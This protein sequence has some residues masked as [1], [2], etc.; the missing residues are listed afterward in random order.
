MPT[1]MH[2]TVSVKAKLAAFRK[3]Y[4][5]T[6]SRAGERSILPTAERAR[7]LR[8]TTRRLSNLLSLTVAGV[9]R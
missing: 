8:R 1:V 6:V 4:V 5:L 3:T 9:R 7:S 2:R